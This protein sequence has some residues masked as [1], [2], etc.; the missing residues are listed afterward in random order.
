MSAHTHTLVVLSIGA[1]AKP[2]THTRKPN[3]YY[4]NRIR[5]ITHQQRL[6][7]WFYTFVGNVLS[8]V[9][10]D[11][12]CRTIEPTAVCWQ[13]DKHIGRMCA[14]VAAATYDKY[15]NNNVCVCACVVT[16][17]TMCPTMVAISTNA[18]TFC[19]LIL[20]HNNNGFDP[21][22]ERKIFRK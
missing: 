5:C 14:L 20:I 11:G 19:T 18:Y 4:T 9:G 13:H 22:D 17:N 16:E 21:H 1:L 7:N 12:D 10:R 8:A 2:T 15:N 6:L 3:A